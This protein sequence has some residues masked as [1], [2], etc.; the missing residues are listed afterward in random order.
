M[1]N[2]LNTAL[3]LTSHF[4]LLFT[5]V[6]ADAKDGVQPINGPINTTIQTE[7]GQQIP[8]G[9]FGVIQ[10]DAPRVATLLQLRGITGRGT[11]ILRSDAGEDC[12]TL[13][14][15]FVAGDFGGESISSHAASSIILTIQTERV[16]NALASGD[17]VVS[18]MYRISSLTDDP[19]ADIIIQSGLSESH[20]FV[21]NPGSSVV[22][23]IFGTTAS[24]TACSA[25]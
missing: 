4:A 18:D 20:G 5:S 24:R 3:F 8:A 25:L 9:A 1:S 22:A 17:D 16:A 23:D 10:I 12:L 7:A 14:I 11:V 19:N 6:I 13:P 21:L 2:H 15:R